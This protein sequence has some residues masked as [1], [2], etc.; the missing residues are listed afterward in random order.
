M[1][2]S[3]SSASSSS[4]PPSSDPLLLPRLAH[5]L[6]LISTTNPRTIPS[7][8]TQPRR[9]SVA[10]LIRIRP[11]SKDQD[12][13]AQCYDS[14]GMPIKGSE[15][16][17]DFT[18]SSSNETS[19]GG[20]G[21]VDQRQDG[22]VVGSGIGEEEVETIKRQEIER[23]VLGERIGMEESQASIL[24]DESLVDVSKIQ[25]SEASLID[26]P[27]NKDQITVG[28][29]QIPADS[30]VPKSKPSPISTSSTPSSPST[31]YTQFFSQPWVQ[32]GIPELLFIKDLPDLVIHGHLMWLSL[33]VEG[34]N[35]MRTVFTP[36]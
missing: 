25:D 30:K 12:R 36:P 5:A 27:V 2:S 33:E 35:L 8:S 31:P 1:S 6:S 20:V 14:E 11:S 7:P 24:K 26:V 4:N 23:K 17:V 16:D 28:Q 21:G 18:N 9:A 10:L 19:E 34:K 29:D 15:V 22:T 32:N 3:S 13:L